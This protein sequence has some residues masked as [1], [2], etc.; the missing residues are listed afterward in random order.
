ML[1]IAAVGLALALH[2]VGPAPADRPDVVLITLDTTRADHVGRMVDGRTLTPTLDALAARGT[3]FSRAVAPAPLTLPAHC[4]LMTGVDPPRHGVRDNGASRLPDDLPTLASVFRGKGYATGA[5]VASL[6]LDRRFG[7]DRG[8]DAYD[9]AMVAERTGEQGYPERTAAEGTDA[10]LAW[11]SK[12]PAGRPRLL[13]VHYY[14]PHAPYEP[15]GSWS[16]APAARRY[17][18]EIAVVDRE[19]GQL[20]DRLPASAAGRIVALLLYAP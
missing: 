11:A 4:T 15:P 14:D 17:A 13:W 8:F 18:A 5:V 6:V 16:G 19:V 12:A 3:R 2:S 9:D 10:A 20:L 7:L 1:P